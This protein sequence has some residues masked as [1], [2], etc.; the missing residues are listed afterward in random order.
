L[1][2][3]E[4]PTQNATSDQLVGRRRKRGMALATMQKANLDEATVEVH[5][6]ISRKTVDLDG[7]K[8]MQMTF[9]PGARWST[10]LKPDVGTEL[11]QAPHV[12]LVLSGTLH[13][14]LQDGSVREF[15][16]HDV[17]M[18]PPGHD[19]WSV[20]DQPCVFVE[21]SRGDDYYTS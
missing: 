15:S 6:R 20:G 3:Q 13:V 4:F 11:C 12:A 10:D 2:E 19:A 8:V 1:D 7:V 5:G 14:E 9:G 18:I 21:F 16:R 17:M